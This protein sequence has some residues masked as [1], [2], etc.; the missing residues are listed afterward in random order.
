MKTAQQIAQPQIARWQLEISRDPVSNMRRKVKGY[1]LK[2]LRRSVELVCEVSWLDESGN[3]IVNETRFEPY[4]VILRAYCD[5]NGPFIDPS[6]G[7]RV[8]AILD[9]NNQ[10]T[11]YNQYIFP[12]STITRYAAIMGLCA[13][14]LYAIDEE[15]YGFI[16]SADANH[17]YDI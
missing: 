11:T 16:Q 4:P 14:K 2:F 9:T 3:E 8:I 13:T 10:S 5:E 12:D 7:Q 6:T 1:D 15:V 17:E